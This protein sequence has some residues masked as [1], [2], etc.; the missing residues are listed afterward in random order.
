MRLP[1]LTEDFLQTVRSIAS[2]EYGSRYNQ[3]QPWIHQLPDARSGIRE[4]QIEIVELPELPCEVAARTESDAVNGIALYERL[5]VLSPV[6]ASDERL[7]ACLSHTQYWNYMCLRWPRGSEDSF[8]SIETRWFFKGSSMERLARNGLARLWWGAYA[9]VVPEAPEPYRLT[10]VLFK[11]TEI[12]FGYMERL[13]GKNRCVLHAALD[14]T[15]RNEPRIKRR[16]SLSDWARET[17]KLINRIGGVLQLDALSAAD[18]EE[19]LEKHLQEL[20]RRNPRQ[21]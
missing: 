13:F 1:Y 17:G 16:Q 20:Y 12:Q 18:V 9:T 3:S 5:K 21:S 6:Q 19:I 11:N 14:F 15:E 8:E 10:R 4:S 7:W 2:R